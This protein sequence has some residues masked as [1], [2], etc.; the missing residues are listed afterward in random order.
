[1]H[2]QRAIIFVPILITAATWR[3]FAVMHRQAQASRPFGE[4][5]APQ[6]AAQAVVSSTVRKNVRC[7]LGNAPVIHRVQSSLRIDLT[8]RT[9][10]FDLVLQRVLSSLARQFIIASHRKAVG[11]VRYRA[12]PSHPVY[13]ASGFSRRTLGIA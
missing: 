7:R 3:N 8:V 1:M 9:E 12:I 5:P 13:H 4:Q 2:N 10:Q 6:P 11:N